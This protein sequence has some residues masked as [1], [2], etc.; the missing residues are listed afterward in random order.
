MPDHSTFSKNR[1]GRFRDSDAFR[2]LFETVVERCIEEGLVGGEGFAIDASIIRADANRD[3]GCADGADR[4]AGAEQRSRAVREYLAALDEAGA[5]RRDAE[6]HLDDRSGR[7]LDGGAG[8]AS[9]LRLLDQ[10]PD[11]R[12]VPGDRGRRGDARASH[13]RDR[14]DKMMIERVEERL[15]LKPQRLIGDTAYGTAPMLEWMVEDKGI[16]P[17]VPVW[18]KVR[19]HDGTFLGERLPVERAGQRVPLSARSSRFAATGA[20]SSKPA[21]RVTLADT[22]I[23]RASQTGLRRVPAEGYAAA[24]TR[25]TRHDCAEHLRELTRGGAQSRGDR[26]IQAVAQRPQEGRDVVRASQAHPEARPA[27]TARSVRRRD[28]FL[29]A[30]TAQN[31]RRMA[32]RWQQMTMMKPIEAT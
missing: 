31:L 23:Y 30:A 13:G 9:L 2:Q 1:H 3:V 11:R 8:W 6:V 16:A 25:P 29:L 14:G 21:H 12:G 5:G 18:E 10:L 22:I 7:S 27:A 19:R 28:E 15:D 32:K 17:H 26:R 4:L 20:R 24:R